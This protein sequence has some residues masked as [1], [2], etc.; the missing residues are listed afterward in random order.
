MNQPVQLNSDVL[1][2]GIAESKEEDKLQL[3]GKKID[4]V[5][6]KDFRLTCDKF[7]VINLSF[8]ELDTID[9][10]KEC[11]NVRELWLSDNR[12]AKGLSKGLQK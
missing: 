8:N 11:K 6:T 3:S 4:D 5:Q 2:Q 9:G 1:S 10:F 7:T 12:I